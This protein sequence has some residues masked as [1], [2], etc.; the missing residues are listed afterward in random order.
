MANLVLQNNK[1][2][3][4]LCKELLND[5]DSW[6]EENAIYYHTLHPELTIEICYD[7]DRIVQ[8]ENKE[9]Y[10][11][12]QTNQSTRY[13]TAK[14]YFQATR[15]FSCQITMLDANRMVAPC[16]KWEFIHYKNNT[17]PAISYKCYLKTSIEY[18]LLHFLLL[19]W[20]EVTGHEASIAVRKLLEV[21]LL[22]DDAEQVAQFE[23]YVVQHF[24]RFEALIKMQKPVNL[25]GVPENIAKV[26]AERIQNAKALKI[27]QQEWQDEKIS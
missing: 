16:P 23:S 11:F 21:V 24:D 4:Q 7:E 9:F 5:P 3:L 22:F 26:C 12:L 20:D 1:P 19:K 10:H 17:D 27:M 15:I 13:G 18:A 8:A 6:V 14:F 2:P 25:W